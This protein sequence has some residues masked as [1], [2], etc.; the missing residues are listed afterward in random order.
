[1]AVFVDESKR[2]ELLCAN[3]M[4]LVIVLSAPLHAAHVK[5]LVI[6][7]MDNNELRGQTYLVRSEM[8]SVS[9]VFNGID[10]PRH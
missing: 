6:M 5:S 3:H 10:D 2:S 7:L 1:M 8:Y 9:C 4:G